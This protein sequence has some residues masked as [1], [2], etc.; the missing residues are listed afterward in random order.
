MKILVTGA[1]GFIGSHLSERLIRAGHVVT[2]VDNF[3]PFYDKTLKTSNLEEVSRAGPFEFKEMDLLDGEAMGALWKAR[4]PF[5]VVVHLAALAGVRPSL[6][7]P[8]RYEQVNVEGTL[9]LLERL[10]TEGS[11]RTRMVFASSSSVYG[12]RSQVPFDEKDPCNHPVS[13]YAA[14]KR[15]GELL[16]STYN[17]LYGLDVSCLRFFTVYGPRQR[18]EMAIAKFT[19]KVAR[20]ETITLFG[21]GSSAR[22]YTFIDDIIDGT[23]AAVERAPKGF[24]IFNLGG[25]KTVTLAGLVEAIEAALGVSADK[26][27]EDPQPGDVPITYARVEHAG[28]VLGYEPKVRL[29]EG[30]RRYVDWARRKERI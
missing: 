18:P 4:G 21:D 1:A 3:D 6:A 14:T 22:D 12:A 25:S 28:E 17:H 15:C 19:R 13:P 5:D 10:R 24:H 9:K 30:L 29:E 26:V 27:F 2:G 11:T 16:C 8:L 23:Q 7:R 20:G